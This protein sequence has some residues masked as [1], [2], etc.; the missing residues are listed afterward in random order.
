MST[1]TSQG[2]IKVRCDVSNS[3]NHKTKVYFIPEQNYS[4]KHKNKNYAVFVPLSCG[5]SDCGCSDCGC[6]DRGCSDRGCSDRGCSDCKPHCPQSAIIRKYNPDDGC[7][8]EMHM[9]GASCL[10]TVSAAALHQKKVQVEVKAVLKKEAKKKIVRAA[11]KVKTADAEGNRA[12]KKAV[13]RLMKTIGESK[14]RLKLVS[15][16]MPTN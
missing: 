2:T 11:K 14:Q 16:T 4:I 10:H 3:T 15:V 6:S 9:S 12:V 13:K 5:R 7:E 8:I 1:Y